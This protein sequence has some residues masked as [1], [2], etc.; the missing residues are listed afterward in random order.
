VAAALNAVSGGTSTGSAIENTVPPLRGQ[1]HS[2]G[3]R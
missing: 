3:R 1:A 2:A